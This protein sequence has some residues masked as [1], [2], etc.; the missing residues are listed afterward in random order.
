MTTV[1][2]P[3]AAYKT[4]LRD[5]IDRR[6]SGTRQKIAHALRKHKSFVSQITNP[7]YAVPVPAKHLATIFE[8]CHLSPVERRRFM[9]AYRRAHPRSRLETSET[10]QGSSTTLS[11]EVPALKDARRREELIASI[12]LYAEQAIAL[13]HRWDERDAANKHGG[14]DNEKTD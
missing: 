1:K 5:M 12:Q 13:A 4:L 6:P 2:D 10:P 11:I 7:A 9:A 14:P 3:V 8:L